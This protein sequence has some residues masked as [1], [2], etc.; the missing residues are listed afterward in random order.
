MAAMAAMAARASVER[1]AG[2]DLGSFQTTGKMRGLVNGALTD[3]LVIETARSVVTFCNSRDYDCRAQQ[4]RSWLAEHFQFINDP[5]GVEL[6]S[7]PRYL[8]N[9]IATRGYAQGDCDDV[10]ILAATL[11]KAVGLRAKFVLVGFEGPRA[12]FRHVF[13]ILRGSKSWYSMD[14]TKPQ[15]PDLPKVTRAQE[16]EV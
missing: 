15:R 11:G 14:V 12:P 13:T 6:L 3:P 7:T 2:G 16:V 4:I 5:Y 10:S 8:L 9:A 1:I